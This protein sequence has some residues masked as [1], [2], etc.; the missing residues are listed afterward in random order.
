MYICFACQI[1][2]RI[3]IC[4]NQENKSTIVMTFQ[5]SVKFLGWQML[6]RMHPLR[7]LPN[8]WI[9]TNVFVGD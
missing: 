2:L 7:E 8:V 6:V 9:Y 4:L 1:E 5:H 3:L